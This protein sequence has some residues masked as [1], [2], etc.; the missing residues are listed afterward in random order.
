[1]T[2][3]QYQTIDLC[4]RHLPDVL[5]IC[6]Q[7]LGADYHSEADFNECLASNGKRFCKVILDDGGSVC[8]FGIAMMMDSESAD[9]FLKLP[10]SKERDKL[11]SAGKIGILDAGA[12]DNARKGVGLGR[13]L[14]RASRKK[15][16][17]EGADVICSMA[18]KSIHGVTNAER[19]LVENGLEESIA[20]QGY[21][22]QVVDSPQG[23]LCP[24]CK[25][26]PCRCYG[27]LYVRYV[28]R[29]KT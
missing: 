18:W 14:A 6:R 13:L 12:V 20:I 22:N 28:T 4:E 8:G 17:D 5:R 26:P 10:D 7:E 27:V 11:L 15:L 24:V 3:E 19:I 9:E 29:E 16:L 2:S 23:H 21:W 25:E 1:M